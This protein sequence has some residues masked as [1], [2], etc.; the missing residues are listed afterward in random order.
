MDDRTAVYID[1]TAVQPS[2]IAEILN[3]AEFNL[4]GHE[5]KDDLY[6]LMGCG[7]KTFT[8]V[9]DTA[10]AEYVLEPSKSSYALKNIVLEK[11]HLDIEVDKD[12]TVGSQIDFF[13]DNRS[14]NI[15]QGVRLSSAVKALKAKQEVQL[16][17]EGLIKVF[18]EAELPLIEV[19]AAMEVE[20]IKV[21]GSFLEEF[22]EELKKQI[23]KLEEDIYKMAGCLDIRVR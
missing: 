12:V 5:I 23:S 16:R 4:I 10:V 14:K 18:D 20:G 11:L 17:E 3:K 6:Q 19:M 13:E 2:A 8:V 22:G 1:A 21:N 15:E 9:F 7:F